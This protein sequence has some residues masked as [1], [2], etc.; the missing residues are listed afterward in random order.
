MGDGLQ[1]ANGENLIAPVVDLHELAVL[2]KDHLAGVLQEGGDIGSNEEL[3][4]AH[5]HDEGRG[6]TGRVEGVRIL[7]AH[8]ADGVGAVGHGQSL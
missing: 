5:A 4:R 2:E 3:A 7:L 1:A 6:K 8:E